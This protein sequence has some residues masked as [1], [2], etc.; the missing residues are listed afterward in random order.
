MWQHRSFRLLWHNMTP[1][2][3]WRTLDSSVSHADTS[4]SVALQ[5]LTSGQRPLVAQAVIDVVVG[6][7]IFNLSFVLALQ[8][9]AR[10]PEGSL[11]RLCNLPSRT[12]GSVVCTLRSYTLAKERR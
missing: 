9:A 4:R 5:D 3:L 8:L 6:A 1:W 10:C 11:G 2:P 7:A 12:C